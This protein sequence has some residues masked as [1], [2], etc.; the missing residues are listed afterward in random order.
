MNIK[1]SEQSKPLVSV[2]IPA[3]N[4][5]RTICTTI[6]S[7]LNQTYKNLE[8]IV[9]DDGSRDRTA[10]LVQE[11][12]QQDERVVLIK[13]ANAGV[14]KARNKGIEESQGEYVAPIDADDI[15]FPDKIELQVQCMLSSPASVGLVYTWSVCIDYQGKIFGKY[16]A[17]VYQKKHS[18]TGC[19]LPALAYTNFLNN[20]S[21]PLIR[22]SCFA[23]IGGYDP[24][25][26]QQQAQG[27]EDLD[28][29][30]RIAEYYEFQVVPKFLMGYRQEINSMSRNCAAMA[31]SYS[32][33]IT[34]LRSR[35][36]ELPDYLFRWSES[37][38]YNY[39]M[40]QNLGS[41]NHWKSIYWIYQVL[42]VD[43]AIILHPGIY[44][45]L[46]ICTLKILAQPVT[47]LIWQDHQAWIEFKAKFGIERQEYA[48]LSDLQQTLK[49]RKTLLRRP[50]D[51][52]LWYRW[53]R[54]F[55][56]CQKS[57][58]QLEPRQADYL[59]QAKN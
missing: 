23:K 42:K 35:C 27:C 32:L 40:C 9:V 17:D 59:V 28:L 49:R 41:G 50:Y 24:Q 33:V 43:W 37:C 48:N 13:Q 47:S 44:K 58:I 4:A 12:V 30:L 34:K 39:L 31:K 52:I 55:K 8:V 56:L 25:L 2:I 19:I 22:R 14:A 29:Y 5:A 26:K 51:Y 1:L 53:N 57:S 45:I 38:F 21:L 16:L 6:N 7:V 54:V 3:Y 11:I 18:L 15:W 46:F 36:Q 20:A 10:E